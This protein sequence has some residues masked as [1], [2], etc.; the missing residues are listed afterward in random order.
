MRMLI[1]AFA[2]LFLFAPLAEAQQRA[3]HTAQPAEPA[4]G[5]ENCRIER[6]VMARGG[7][8]LLCDGRL[9]AF[10][11]GSQPGGISAFMSW[12]ID[13]R[14]RQASARD[15]VTIVFGPADAAH[16]AICDAADMPGPTNRQP[17]TC[18]AIHAA[19]R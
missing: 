9:Y 17:I 10:D 11:G 14:G 15:S 16:Q 13:A 5:Q 8:A 2:A 1:A 3:I 18:R 6:I 7:A 4:S 12:A 19:H